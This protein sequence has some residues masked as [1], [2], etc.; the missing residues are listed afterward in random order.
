MA[1]SASDLADVIVV[2]GDI[3]SK[4]RN[5]QFLRLI[6]PEKTIVTVSGNHEHYGM[7]IH[8][9][10]NAMRQA[11]QVHNIH[12]LENDEVVI[13]GVR[14]LGCTLWT[15]FELYNREQ[16][17]NCMLDAQQYLNDFKHIRI[18]NGQW[19]FTPIDSI[20]M[21]KESV[22]W[23]KQKIDEPFDGPTIVVT[24]HAPSY[25][26]VVPRFQGDLLSACFAS[27]LDHLMDGSKIE[28]WVHGHMHDSLDYEVN[29]TRVICNPRGYCRFEG[30]EENSDF[31]PK[32]LIEISKEKLHLLA[33]AP[34]EES[35]PVNKSL[36]STK[37][38]KLI[39]QIDH[40]VKKEYTYENNIDNPVLKYVDLGG[41][42][43][44]FHNLLRNIINNHPLLEKLLIPEVI[45]P[46][47]LAT[48]AFVDEEDPIENLI[49][50]IIKC[51]VK[52]SRAPRRKKR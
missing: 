49:D 34:M 50:E 41:V 15:D 32:L 14:F 27:N 39:W 37:R 19:N 44:E 3:F 28:L 29:G 47:H 11:A 35:L 43:I 20:E 38:D 10:L 13:N 4:G 45:L 33:Q 9:N 36:S 22:K 24:H 30:G 8:K 52:T 7:D 12:F 25:K 16:R 40:L 17:K 26:S 2:P 31:D 42:D 18:D 21:H 46:A 23:L 5:I 1:H 48:L 51:S 6:W